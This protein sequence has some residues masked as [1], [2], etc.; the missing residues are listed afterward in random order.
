MDGKKKRSYSQ[1]LKKAKEC[2]KID[3][4][5]QQIPSSKFSSVADVKNYIQERCLVEQKLNAFY[6]RKMWRRQKWK[7]KQNRN[8]WRDNLVNEIKEKFDEPGK[9]IV[10]AWGT[11]TQYSYKLPIKGSPPGPQKALR[12]YVAKFVPVILTS[13]YRTTVTCSACGNVETK[14]FVDEDGKKVHGL[15]CCDN[16]SENED[17]PRFLSRDYNAAVN[18]RRRCLDRNITSSL[19]LLPLQRTVDINA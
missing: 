7:M 8:R 4:L 13:E 17:H 18:I 5:E 9:Q 19:P 16:N 10:L 1:L 15:R 6:K 3:E 11:G 12:D 14:S 2:K